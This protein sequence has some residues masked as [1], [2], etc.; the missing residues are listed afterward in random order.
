[1]ANRSPAASQNYRL[2]RT[3]YNAISS[4]AF[5]KRSGGIDGRPIDEYIASN[6]EFSFA[7][8]WSASPLIARIGCVAGIRLTGDVVVRSSI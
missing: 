1:M 4:C 2:D 6:V 3:D 8:A 7:G 5:S